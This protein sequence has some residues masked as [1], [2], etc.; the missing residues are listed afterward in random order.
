MRTPRGAVVAV[1]APDTPFTLE[2]SPVLEFQPVVDLADG[3]LLGMEALVRWDHPTLGRLHPARLLPLVEANGDIIPLGEWVLAEACAQARLW[4]PSVQLAV[5]CT[6]SQLRHLDVAGM[7]RAAVET[8]GLAYD[9]LTLEITEDTVADGDAFVELQALSAMGVQLAVDDVGTNWS[10]FEPLR[11]LAVNTVKIDGSFVAGLEPTQGINRLVVETVIHMAH[12]LGMATIAEGVETAAQVALIREFDADAAQ[13]YFFAR[14]MPPEEATAMASGEVVP[15]FSR[16]EAATIVPVRAAGAANGA[17]AAD[18]ADGADAADAADGD[19]G[20]TGDGGIGVAAA[21][22]GKAGDAGG[23]SG[24][25]TGKAA[26][27]SGGPA[28][29]PDVTAIAAPHS[30]GT[31]AKPDGARANGGRRPAGQARKAAAQ[32]KKA[33]GAQKAAKAP[34]AKKSAAP[35]RAGGASGQ[36]DK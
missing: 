6:M 35:K 31:K 10:S 13:G 23:G 20:T 29:V 24:K 1:S 19:A 34:A 27:R 32:P 16:T 36:S 26:P 25:A 15:H 5:N 28:P 21:K 7:V 2:G 17:A 3:R 4:S 11:R 33:A 30:A 22:A 8:S 18:A 12:S 14:P 9:R